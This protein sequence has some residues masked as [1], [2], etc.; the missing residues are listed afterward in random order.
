LHV[1]PH[2]KIIELKHMQQYYGTWVPLRGVCAHGGIAQGKEFK[3]L[4]VFDV[5]SVQNG[6]RNIKLAGATM[7]RGGGKSEEDW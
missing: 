6:Y 7:G 2:V 1:L 5:F 3:N 4:N